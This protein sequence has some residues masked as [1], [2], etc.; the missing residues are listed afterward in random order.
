MR[1]TEVPRPS[2]SC[3]LPLVMHSGTA[4]GAGGTE[5]SKTQFPPTRSSQSTEGDR[6]RD[7]HRTAWHVHGHGAVGEGGCTQCRRGTQEGLANSALGALRA[8][9]AHRHSTLERSLHN[10]E[11]QARGPRQAEHH[12]GQAGKAGEWRVDR[13]AVV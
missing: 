4:L 5:R 6:H 1:D 9:R 7:N 10:T 3:N 2:T 13:A 8:L 12:G 11:R